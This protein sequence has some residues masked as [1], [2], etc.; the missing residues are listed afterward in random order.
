MHVT[1]ASPYSGQKQIKA[2]L[3]TFRTIRLSAQKATKGYVSR[4][5]SKPS[6]AKCRRPETANDISIILCVTMLTYRPH[7][8]HHRQHHRSPTTAATPTLSS[9]VSTACS[10]TRHQ[11]LRRRGRPLLNR[12]PAGYAGNIAEVN[13]TDICWS[14]GV[15]SEIL[16]VISV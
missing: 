16:N 5:R 1:S 6:R 10:S 9:S 13:T 15:R 8:R 11:R 3:L 14:G 12:S 7:C 2:Q 4:S